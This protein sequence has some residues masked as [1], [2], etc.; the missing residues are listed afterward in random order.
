MAI[1]KTVY[2]V[3]NSETVPAD[4]LPR[5]K[6]V[7]VHF[8]WNFMA[9]VPGKIYQAHQRVDSLQQTILLLMNAMNLLLQQ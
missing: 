7:E 5:L 8:A 2:Q 1:A 6:K 4:K 9:K 3:G